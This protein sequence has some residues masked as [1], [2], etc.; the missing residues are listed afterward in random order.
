MSK[1]NNHFTIIFIYLFSYFV[2][3][4]SITYLKILDK[5]FENRS[6]CIFNILFLENHFIKNM[7]KNDKYAK[8]LNC[9]KKDF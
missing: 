8:S 4:F 1:V 9:F 7:A 2:N 5:Q 3:C 6:K